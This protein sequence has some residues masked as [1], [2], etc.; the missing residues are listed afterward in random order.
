MLLKALLSRHAR[1]PVWFRSVPVIAI[2]H[3]SSRI[4]AGDHPVG[5]ISTAN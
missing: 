1:L 5:P 3:R 4:A 2:I